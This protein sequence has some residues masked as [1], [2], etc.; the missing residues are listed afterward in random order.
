MAE[1]RKRNKKRSDLPTFNTPPEPPAGTD[2]NIDKILKLL[3]LG[4]TQFL[5]DQCV[6]GR[7]RDWDINEIY[8]NAIPENS[9][10]I[11]LL[12]HSDDIIIVSHDEMLMN[13]AKTELLQ[14]FE[15]TDNRIFCGVEV[16]TSASQISLS[17]EYYWD[18]LMQN[19]TFN[20]TKSKNLH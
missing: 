14:V 1:K 15:G 6:Y 20:M 11:F 8:D 17:M 5:T 18:K 16:R 19:S 4:D 7:W 2:T 10:F 12:M 9:S 3:Q 13:A